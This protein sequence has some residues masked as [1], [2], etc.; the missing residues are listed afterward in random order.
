MNHY[1]GTVSAGG[2]LRGM[3]NP[4]VAEDIALPPTFEYRGVSLSLTTR[5]V[6]FARVRV[7]EEGVRGSIITRAVRQQG[8][9]CCALAGFSCGDQPQ[10]A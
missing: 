4:I 1:S 5:A 9:L 8:D 3:E 6:Y 7:N 10:P 2:K